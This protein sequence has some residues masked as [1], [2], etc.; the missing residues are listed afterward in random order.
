MYKFWPYGSNGRINTVKYVIIILNLTENMLDKPFIADHD[1]R[2]NV[3]GIPIN[4]YFKI[5]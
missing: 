3:Y 2:V 1:I 5:Y 4:V